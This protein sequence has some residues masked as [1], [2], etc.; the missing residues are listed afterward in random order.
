MTNDEV[1]NTLKAIIR[2]LERRQKELEQVEK[3]LPG[4]EAD[5]PAQLNQVYKRKINVI[6]SIKDLRLRLNRRELKKSLSQEVTPL[7]AARKSAME[8]AL[9]AVS[10]SISDVRTFQAS[11]ALAASIAK[12]AE[13]ADAASVVA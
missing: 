9:Q 13:S 8:R 12:A 11:I 10:A 6:A 3:N 2:E 7:S 1:I 5:I 4:P